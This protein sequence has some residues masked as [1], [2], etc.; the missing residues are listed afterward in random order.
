[1]LLVTLIA[2]ALDLQKKKAA[3]GM[4]LAA[5]KLAFGWGLLKEA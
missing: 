2:E 1:L 4:L 3:N 5:F